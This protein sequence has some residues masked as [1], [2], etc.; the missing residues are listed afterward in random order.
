VELFRRLCSGC[1][2]LERE[3]PA[4]VIRLKGLGDGFHGLPAHLRTPLRRLFRDLDLVVGPGDVIG[5]INPGLFSI[6]DT[7]SAGPPLRFA[8]I[9]RFSPELFGVLRNQDIARSKAFAKEVMEAAGV[10]A[11]RRLDRAEA[12]CVVKYDG[13]AAGKGVFV[14]RTPEELALGQHQVHA[15]RLDAGEPHLGGVL[16]LQSRLKELYG[17]VDNCCVMSSGVLPPGIRGER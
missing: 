2:F 12:P 4:V 17:L 13:L 9:P 15:G 16:T 6:G 5:L 1:P 14:C 8:A 3:N 11:T 10:P 7:V